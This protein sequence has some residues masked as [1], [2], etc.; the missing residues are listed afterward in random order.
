MTCDIGAAG[1][2]LWQ[3]IVLPKGKGKTT[4]P[5]TGS[6]GGHTNRNQQ[7]MAGAYIYY[8]VC[9]NV[10]MLMYFST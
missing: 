3:D 10:Y 9:T 1:M 8:F 2:K 6:I 5:P 4:P 7:A